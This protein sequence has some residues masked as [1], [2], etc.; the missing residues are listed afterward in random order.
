MTVAAVYAH[1]V[2]DDEFTAL[3]P[4]T[5]D[6]DLMVML[7]VT[8][9]VVRRRAERLGLSKD[10]AHVSHVKSEAHRGDKHYAWKGPERQEE[11]EHLRIT[12]EYKEWRRAVLE[13]DAYTCAWCGYEGTTHTMHA[14]H[15]KAW[16]EYVELRTVISN[17]V[18]LCRNCHADYHGLTIRR[19]E[20]IPCRCGCETIIDTID[21]WG[22]RRQYVKGHQHKGKRFTDEHRA[23]LSVAR[24]NSPRG[25]LSD[26]H[27]A[28]VG[29]A[30]RGKKRTPEYCAAHSERKKGWQPSDETRAR[31]SATHLAM[32]KKEWTNDAMTKEE[33]IALYP[34]M[35]NVELARRCHFSSSAIS[36]WAHRLNLPGKP[37]G[38]PPRVA[39]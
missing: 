24:R 3:F 18:A 2:T 16:A 31:M 35:T 25:P 4:V 37:R 21:K 6:I 23:A 26:E 7:G 29:A 33:F 34:T 30:N 19:R 17:G 28:K 9:S 10:P 8:K 14:H 11:R 20:R 32:G 36:W 15:I 12:P 22:Y 1:P 39:P 13:R 27:K 38:C 5:R